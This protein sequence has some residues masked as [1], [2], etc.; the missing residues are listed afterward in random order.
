M[1]LTPVDT[2]MTGRHACHRL[3]RLS[4]VVVI[5]FAAARHNDPCYDVCKNADTVEEYGKDPQEPYDGGVDPEIFSNAS[6][7]TGDF[8][9]G[10]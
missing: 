2:P 5:A 3:S 7:Y 8:F 6:A 1:R 10:S 4:P 9:I